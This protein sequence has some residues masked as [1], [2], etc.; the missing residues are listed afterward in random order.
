MYHAVR[1]Y[2]DNGG[3]P[4]YIFSVAIYP[5]GGAAPQADLYDDS[6]AF[7]SINTDK[8]NR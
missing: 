6:K 4:C 8:E 2:F 7:F 5:A 3:G 1:N